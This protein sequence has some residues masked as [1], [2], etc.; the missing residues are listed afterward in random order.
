[1]IL[2]E[3]DLRE[4]LDGERIQLRDSL[5]DSVSSHVLEA[6]FTV[7]REEFMDPMQRFDAY[8][9]EAQP[10]PGNEEEAS[11]SQPSV[12]AQMLELL[13]PQP[14]DFVIEV[15]TATGYQAAV[16]SHLA[17]HVVTYEI[18]PQLAET[19]SQRLEKLGITNV[20]I[21]GIDAN[22]EGITLPEKADKLIV[23]ASVF[24]S[25]YL[26]FYELVREGGT[27][28]VP[29]GGV[30]GEKNFCDLVHMQKT[31]DGVQLERKIP[32]YSFVPMEGAHGWTTY[33]AA[34]TQAHNKHFY[35]DL[36]KSSFPTT[37]EP[38]ESV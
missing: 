5:K 15:G 34:I 12:I 8:E 13:D 33:L 28:V 37:E 10:I 24:P 29:V 35:E 1:M 27:I 36:M 16:L 2:A 4:H 31:K 23:T 21:M 22:A 3:R 17:R 18:L 11:I 32:G 26:P 20:E 14:S 38:P 30:A 6:M 9:N 25:A 19:A 7:P